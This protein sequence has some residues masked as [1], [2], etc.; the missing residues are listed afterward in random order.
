MLAR[1][2]EALLPCIGQLLMPLTRPYLLGHS[3]RAE[4]CRNAELKDGYS[5][6]S[7][8]EPWHARVCKSGLQQLARKLLLRISRY[9]R[10]PGDISATS[11]HSDE[12]L[13][14]GVW[15]VRTLLNGQEA[16]NGQLP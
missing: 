12:A 4:D 1:C 6:G 13:R 8:R 14:R 2:L 15:L 5:S 7:R 9:E 16:G 10:Y 11:W 3:E